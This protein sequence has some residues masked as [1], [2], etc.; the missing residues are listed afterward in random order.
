MDLFRIKAQISAIRKES[1][2]LNL[3]VNLENVEQDRLL[4][5][6]EI[7]RGLVDQAEA[8]VKHD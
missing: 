6:L 4:R 1:C 2:A 3:Y 8:M 7:I 5:D